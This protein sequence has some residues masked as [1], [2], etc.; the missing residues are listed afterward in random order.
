MEQRF[1]LGHPIC[2]VDPQIKIRSGCEY[3]DIG[4]CYLI[5]VNF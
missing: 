4:S 1:A 2:D 3:V 5:T